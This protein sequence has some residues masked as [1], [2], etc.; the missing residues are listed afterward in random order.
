[1]IQLT[2]VEDQAMALIVGDPSFDRLFAGIR[3]DQIDGDILYV[4]AEDDET[5]AKMEDKFAL[6]ISTIAADILKREIGIVQ[7]LSRQLAP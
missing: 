1:M 5:A 6:H 3:F 4:Y 7:V 2:P